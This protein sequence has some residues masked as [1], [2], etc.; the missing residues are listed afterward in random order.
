MKVSVI[1]L[2]FNSAKLV[3]Y[4]VDHNGSYKAYQQEGSKV[5]LGQDLA[6][7]GI[8]AQ[9]PMKRTIDILRLFQDIVD[10]QSIKHVVPVAT[11]AVREATN[12][13]GFLEQVFQETGLR[14]R[15]LSDKEEALYSYL[16]A[17]RSLFRFRRREFGI[18]IHRKSQNQEVYFT[19]SWRIKVIPNLQRFRWSV[20][21]EKLFQNGRTCI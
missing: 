6:Q 7:T 16:G 3:N 5:S 11:S 18:S 19:S 1:D 13:T 2:G 15:V 14:F 4:Y 17:H 21:Q 12:G 20:F 9:E 10:F 8:L